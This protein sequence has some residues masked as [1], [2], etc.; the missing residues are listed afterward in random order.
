MIAVPCL[1]VLLPYAGIPEGYL[2]H[3]AVATSLASMM[4]STVS[5]TLSHHKRSG[6][7]WNVFQKLFLGLIVGSIVGSGVAVWLNDVILEI[8]F[9][10]FL[11]FLAVRFYFQKPIHAG[12]HRLPS[13]WILSLFAIGIGAVSNLLGIGGAA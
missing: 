10:A 5:S 6:I 9:G 3:V 12:A 8:V 11:L 4:F 1:L 7:L 13:F 2:M